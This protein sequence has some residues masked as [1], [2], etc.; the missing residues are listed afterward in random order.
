MNNINNPNELTP[1]KCQ[2]DNCVYN[3]NKCC[4]ASKIEVGPTFA[5]TCNDTICKTFKQA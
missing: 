2:V 4:C 5:A 1:V 3:N